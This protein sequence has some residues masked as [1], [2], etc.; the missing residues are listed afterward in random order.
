MVRHVMALSRLC[1]G[2]RGVSVAPFGA[3]KGDANLLQDAIPCG[4]V[5]LQHHPNLPKRSNWIH[6]LQQR[7]RKCASL[8][9]CQSQQ[10]CHVGLE[11][12]NCVI[13]SALPST[14]LFCFSENKFQGARK[15]TLKRRNSNNGP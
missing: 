10:R 15:G 4:G 8:D 12:A 14:E 2:H 3:D 1:F 7:S 6:A 5:R 9:S 13:D 11:G